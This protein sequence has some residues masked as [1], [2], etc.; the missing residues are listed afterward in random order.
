MY[1]SA[2]TAIFQIGGGGASS[3]VF[4]ANI[5]L[6]AMPTPSMTARRTAQPI[7]LLRMALAPPRTASAPPVKK[8]PM[9]AFHGSSFFLQRYQLVRVWLFVAI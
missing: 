3:R 7:A 1:W 2:A 6:N 9:M 4:S 5:L 8:P